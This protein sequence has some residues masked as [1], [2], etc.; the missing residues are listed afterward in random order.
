MPL[1]DRRVDKLSIVAN[2][3]EQLL[4][5]AAERDELADLGL[6]LVGERVP[7]I[8]TTSHF[9]TRIACER[10]ARAAG[11]SLLM[12][13]P[14]YHGTGL[15]ADEAGMIEH[16]ARFRERRPL[17]QADEAGDA[18]TA[19]VQRGRPAVPPPRL[20]FTGLPAT[21]NIKQQLFSLPRSERGARFQGNSSCRSRGR[22]GVRRARSRAAA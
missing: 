4:L 14:P 15:W 9:S 11:A 6:T 2:C 20:P 19:V 12:R 16:F 8:V 7:V 3:S 10:A 21:T 22:A 13:M 18:R 1:V 17:T 5:S